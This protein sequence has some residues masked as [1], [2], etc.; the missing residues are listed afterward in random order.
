[1]L[2]C[3]LPRIWGSTNGRAKA[4]WTDVS[5]RTTL[6]YSTYFSF[7]ALG[8]VGHVI[9]L[10]SRRRNSWTFQTYVSIVCLHAHFIIISFTVFVM[11]MILLSWIIL[12]IL[13]LLRSPF[14]AILGESILTVLTCLLSVSVYTT[15]DGPSAQSW[16]LV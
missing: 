11:M 5:Y 2:V 6:P 8:T 9:T 1:M 3:L 4:T 15:H 13:H 14:H 10:C 16:A 12:S 7:Y